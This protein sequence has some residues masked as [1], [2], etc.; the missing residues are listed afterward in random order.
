M[1]LPLTFFIGKGGIG[2][3]TVSAAYAV[4]SAA[5]YPRKK[6][7]LV[8]TDPAHSLADV[9]QLKVTRE[10][11]KIPRCPNLQ[12]WQVDAERRFQEFLEEYRGPISELIESGTFL[13][14][15]EIDSFLKTTLPGL[16][17][18]SALLTIHDLLESGKYDEIVV[19]TAPIGHT[20]QL[21]RIPEQLA[22]F[23]EFLELSGKRDAVLAAHF[24]GVTQEKRIPVLERWEQVLSDLR[25]ALSKTSSRLVMVT[26]AEKFS[27]E[28]SKRT[29]A[30]LTTDSNVQISEVILNRVVLVAPKCL[31]CK[32]RAKRAQAAM[33]F[34]KKNFRNAA[35]RIGED[36]G[37][38]ILGT[39]ALKA[40]GKHVFDREKL[41]SAKLFAPPVMAKKRE[42]EFAPVNWPREAAELTLTL[43]KGG[44]GKT[45]VS[46]GLALTLRKAHKAKP[47]LICST[48]PAPSL[49]DAFGREIG[50]EPIPV[51]Q[52]RKF[53]ACELDST[54]EYR[55]WS[56]RL[57][58]QLSQSLQIQQGGLHVELSF[59]HEMIAALL[60]IVPPGVDEVFAVFK[61]FDLLTVR[62]QSVVIDMAPTGH[63]LELLKTPERLMVWS[64]LLLKSLAAHR[65][66]PI[67]QDLAVEVASISQRARELVEMLKDKNRSRIFVVML[68]EPMPDQQTRRLL[69]D[70][71]DLELYPQAVFI[72]R[73]LFA[74]DIKQCVR[75]Q[76]AYR[77]QLAT[78]S[79]H[80]VTWKGFHSGL[81]YGIR[82]FS[83]D[84]SGKH[85]L[86]ILTRE[87]WQLD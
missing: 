58:Q 60:D 71:K 24:A 9:F 34:L 37:G 28:E 69:T 70:L 82:D 7:V 47:V 10:L 22:R 3:T 35:V 61:I 87:L 5:K 15:K 23:L 53:T 31:R 43:G 54:A 41:G 59:E 36:P 42:L 29:A 8:S 45:T 57:K 86:E 49:D 51:L 66:L 11:Q 81:R 25:G 62:G 12:L 40:F 30:Q 78:L 19:D 63:A 18:M 52:D 74:E 27:L 48:D 79:E 16:A 83:A 67:A 2:K 55:R 32:L 1:S 46:S 72:N 65:S 33:Q 4:R 20:L 13:S 80:A 56:E 50:P 73:V 84:I 85:G 17:E 39:T 14:R 21:F 68:A 77:W 6:F 44:V 76:T 75:C 38:P 64:R 26:S